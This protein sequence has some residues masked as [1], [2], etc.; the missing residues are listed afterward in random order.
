MKE[1]TFKQGLNTFNLFFITTFLVLALYSAL[2]QQIFPYIGQY[3]AD[4][5]KYVSTQLKSDVN[6]R[7]LSG[8]MNI[9]TP[10]IHLEGVT[11][12]SSDSQSIP[13]LSIAAIDAI[14]DPQ[15]S[16]LN[17][18]PVFKSVRIS[19][20]YINLSGKKDN[21]SGSDNGALIQSFIEVLL[22]Q[23]HL[24]LNNV[25]VEFS[26]GSTSERLH[27]N[28]LS[29]TGDGFHRLMTGSVTLGNDNK[30]KAGVRLY[31]EG[32]PYDLEEFYAR[33][34]L[35]L[36]KLDVDHWL[37]KISDVSIFDEFSASSQL[38]MEFQ[39]GLLNYAKLNLASRAV[40]VPGVKTFK[41][42]GAELWLKQNNVDTWS[43]WLENA[44]FSL[45]QKKWN[46]NGLALKLSKTLNGNRWHTFISDADISETYSLVD[47]LNL[48]PESVLG[49]Y[50]DLSPTG[51]LTNFNII[52]QQDNR[53][54]DA[55]QAL[56]LAGELKGVSTKAHNSIPSLTNVNGVIAAGKDNGRV[57]FEG[58]DIEIGFP[59]LYSSSFKLSQGK[60]QVDWRILDRGF[61]ITGNGLNVEMAGVQKLK[62]GFDLYL[63]ATDIQETGTLELNLSVTDTDV[64]AHS[65]LVPKVTP[66][67]LNDWLASALKGGRVS[68]GQFYYYDSIGEG[69]SDPIL[70]LYLDAHNA[71]LAYLEG[72]PAIQNINGHVYVHN[73]DVY[74]AFS[75]GS[76]LGGELSSA[77]IFYQSGL[78]P[79]L[80]VEGDIKG[81]SNGMFSYFKTTPLKDVVGDVFSDWSMQ[82]VQNTSLGLKIPMEADIEKLKADVKSTLSS[83]SLEM[84]DIGLAI[85][86][87]EGAIRYSSSLGLMSQKLSASMWGETVSAAISSEIFNKDMKTNIEFSSLLNSSKLKDWLKLSILAPISG[88]SLTN[89][90][91]IIDTRS[92][93]F[94]GLKFNSYL[95]GMAI[96]LPGKFS[97]KPKDKVQL[98]GSLELAANQVLKL[99]YGKLVN[100]AVS[101]DKGSLS[102][103]QVYI[104]E[105]EAY[106][107]SGTGI[108]I[109]GHLANVNLNEWIKVWTSIENSPYS[110]LQK[111]ENNVETSLE[112]RPSANPIRLLNVSTDKLSYNNFQFEQVKANIS[113]INNVWKFDVDA[114]V[115]KGFVILD[116]S[117]PLNVSLEYLHWPMLEPSEDKHSDP[118]ADVD[119]SIFP[120]M[121]LNV[122]EIFVGPRN[123]GRWKLDVNKIEN[124]VRFSNVDGLIKKLDVKGDVEWLKYSN[125][126]IPDRTSASLLLTSSDVGG[127]QKAWRMKPAVEAEYGKINT[128]INWIG[129]PASPEID[130]LAGTLDVHLK[131]GRFVDAGD[132]GSLSAFGL[133]NFSAIGRRLRLDFSDVYESGFHFDYVKG[134][135][136]VD[137]GIITVIDTLEIDGPSAKFAAS[138]TVNLNTKE[139]NQELSATFPITSTLPLMAIIAGFAPPIAASLFVGERLV[140][141]QIE[142]FTSATYKLS[143]TWDEPKLDLMKRF[144]NDIEGKQDRSFW[145]RMKDFFGVGEN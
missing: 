119:P 48:I 57:Q 128:N 113:Q 17:L 95:D 53:N 65:I 114:P 89:G 94:T 102:S 19:G 122:S 66:K 120:E 22:L 129:S 144:D 123:L 52:M 134:R 93:G 136:S 100:L 13:S 98:T 90:N 71:E 63:P 81:S 141:D 26:Q 64:I 50:N 69:A 86:D 142:K 135:T 124:G 139:L 24:E 11:M 62:G 118:L 35:D 145:Y 1:L 44:S 47:S 80:W 58:Q 59:D 20:L 4:I 110:D 126:K 70:E 85:T 45:D 7:A 60:G 87:I 103:G 77:Q 105:T 104:G 51:R 28:N 67:A 133:L 132:A 55:P 27:I 106:V 68:Q 3:R 91:V 83:S 99:S 12:S 116:K 117:K 111:T 127:I 2:G 41:N 8:D 36:P 115:A 73:T 33:G 38:S 108:E 23:H 21:V 9:L 72:W 39:H 37:E 54:P 97:K 125:D 42:V 143:G 25:T 61:Q 84:A 43:V 96:N 49:I 16:L 46:L 78:E 32:N 107:P 92:N 138:G 79:Y 140:G 15:A 82:G 130:S 18:A 137:K 6:I 10:S 109:S 121:R 76:S 88:R 5:E 56:T 40:A 34:V 112:A 101:L 74:G 131:G 14:L 31:S 75:S 29:M 30:I